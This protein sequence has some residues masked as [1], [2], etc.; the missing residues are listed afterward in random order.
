MVGNIGV[1][2]IASGAVP[3]LKV[4]REIVAN[5]FEVKKYEPVNSSYF[6]ENEKNFKKILK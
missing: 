4:W 5:S 6:N 3:N 1:L 2:A